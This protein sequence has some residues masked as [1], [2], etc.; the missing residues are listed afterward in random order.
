MSDEK[1][2]GSPL[3]ESLAGARKLKTK[4]RPSSSSAVKKPD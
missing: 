2:K 1:S 3:N 4:K